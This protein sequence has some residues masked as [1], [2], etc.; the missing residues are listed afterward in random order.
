VLSASRVTLVPPHLGSVKERL[1][2]Q[3]ADQGTALD[4]VYQGS[5]PRLQ[6]A[7]QGI[8]RLGLSQGIK[9]RLQL[10]AQLA[11]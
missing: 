6:L 8:P 3:L 9:A 11:P 4:R 10:A 1:A 7:A 5:K 2:S